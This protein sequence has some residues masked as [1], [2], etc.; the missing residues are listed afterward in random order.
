MNI[1][2]SL[3]GLLGLGAV[4]VLESSA[5]GYQLCPNIY[6]QD[7]VPGGS[8]DPTYT[9]G[10]DED[11]WWGPTWDNGISYAL[12]H[13]QY[14]S[15][16]TR[17]RVSSYMFNFNSPPPGYPTPSST[18][19]WMVDANGALLHNSSN[20]AI[21]RALDTTRDGQWSDIDWGGSTCNAGVAAR[22]R[23]YNT[24]NGT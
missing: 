7:S 13:Y 20:S 15:N 3:Y 1:S 17:T 2:K 6:Y 16:P 21:C 22:I 8:P 10:A 9:Y 24:G 11:C 5:L 23:A 18:E 14:L 4:L 19:T 12:G